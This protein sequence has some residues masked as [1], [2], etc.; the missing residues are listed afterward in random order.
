MGIDHR[1]RNGQT[2]SQA[3][4]TSSNGALTLLESIKDF[5]DLVRLDSDPGVGD[6][7]FDLFWCRVLRLY[8]NATVFRREFHTVLDE[9][10]KNL[11]QARGI[12]LHMG[13][14]SAKPEFCLELLG[15][16][17]F[18]T[19][20]VSALQNFVNAHD[21]EA[22]LQLALGDSGDIKQVVDQARFQLNVAADDL[23][24][25]PDVGRGRHGRFQFAHHRDDRR[26]RITQLVGK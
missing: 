9:I 24:C 8:N 25:S 1:L 22:Q 12:T 19:N 7:D 26:E 2:Q 11:L 17:I 15:C 4:E 18:G 6:T 21:L 5:V 3:A 10:P 23:E 13:V 14:D 20:F 16:D